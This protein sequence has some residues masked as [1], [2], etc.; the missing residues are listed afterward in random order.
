[1]EGFALIPAFFP[2]RRSSALACGFVGSLFM[3]LLRYIKRFVRLRRKPFASNAAFE[4]A[5]RAGVSSVAVPEPGTL[6]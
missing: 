3:A 1:M 2:R 6:R 4:S 5:A